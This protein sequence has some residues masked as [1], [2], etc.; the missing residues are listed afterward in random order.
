MITST[1]QFIDPLLKKEE[2]QKRFNICINCESFIKQT[3][4]CKECLCIM[5][6]K[7]KLKN[8][9]CPLNKW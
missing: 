1:L 2:A 5:K 6:F 7:C 8:A 9:K 4:M 3:T